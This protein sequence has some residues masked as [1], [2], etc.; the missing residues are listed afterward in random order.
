LILGGD[1]VVKQALVFKGFS[2]DAPALFEDLLFPAEV[3]IRG[4]RG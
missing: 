2:F 4:G 1:F 3:D